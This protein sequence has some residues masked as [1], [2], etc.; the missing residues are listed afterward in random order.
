MP[1]TAKHTHVSLYQINYSMSNLPLEE[2]YDNTPSFE[3]TIWWVLYQFKKFTARQVILFDE[4]QSWQIK[5]DIELAKAIFKILDGSIITNKE[6]F[7][8]ILDEATLEWLAKIFNSLLVITHSSDDKGEETN[9][10]SEVTI[11]TE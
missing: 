8:R 6:E 2:I 5:D 3:A 1:T 7:S 10:V 11:P 9:E 4:I